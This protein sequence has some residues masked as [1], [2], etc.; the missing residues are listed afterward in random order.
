MDPTA[1]TPP[2]ENEPQPAA[3]S[4]PES[5]KAS[6][7]RY[8]FLGQTTLDEM[9]VYHHN[10]LFYWWPVWFF[11]FVMAGITYF[12]DMRMA[13]V[14]PGTHASPQRAL[15]GD[16]LDEHIKRDVLV[17]LEGASLPKGLTEDGD[18]AP[19]QPTY[20][21]ARSRGWGSLFMVI[22]LIIIIITNVRL[23]GLWS[24][25]V[26][27]VLIMVSLLAT[28]A[29]WWEAIFARLGHLAIYINLGGYLLLSFVL[30]VFWL[31][32]FFIFDRQTYMVFTPGQ[33]RLRL[34]IGDGEIVYDTTGIVVHKRRG[35]LF[36][37]WILGF[38][39]GDLVIR[40]VGVANPIEMTN[41]MRVAKVVKRVESM[42]KERMV[43]TQSPN[44]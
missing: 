43:V 40:P 34:E 39:S 4:R 1:R 22:L 38:G 2:G 23:Q 6:F 32:N 27:I 3:A 35:D 16:K 19:M 5:R 15:V 25:L 20:F 14:P 10:N 44:P 33:V 17:L 37:H 26:L 30:L 18:L 41:V 11:G 31:I 13:I 28:A 36:R 9:A 42:V 8:F 24:F 29:G 21:M 12:G 7:W